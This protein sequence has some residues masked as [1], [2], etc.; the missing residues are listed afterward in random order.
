MSAGGEFEVAGEVRQLL[1][2]GIHHRRLDAEMLAA[3]NCA[4]NFIGA[5]AAGLR[6]A[7]HL[8]L[9]DQRRSESRSAPALACGATENQAI[10]TVFHN[11]MR[12]ARAVRAGDL[13]NRLKTEDAAPT[14]FS[15]PR[16]RILQTVDLPDRIELIDDEPETLVLFGPRHLFKNRDP[17]PG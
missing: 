3:R 6:R 11:R 8:A 13:G 14:E 15:E 7:Q 5:A 17:H 4:Q 12:I 10:A 2:F 9:T 1:D 16:E